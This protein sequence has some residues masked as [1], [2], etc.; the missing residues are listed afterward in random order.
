[1]LVLVSLCTA[2]LGVGG[3]IYEGRRYR[4]EHDVREHRWSS[5]RATEPRE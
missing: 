5:D 1:L 3:L 2:A 4:R